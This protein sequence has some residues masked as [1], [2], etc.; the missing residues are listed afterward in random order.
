MKQ[1]VWEKIKHQNYS[2][3]NVFLI[4]SLYYAYKNTFKIAEVPIHFRK[5]ILGKSKTP[6]L[7]ES[8]KALILPL[9]IRF[10]RRKL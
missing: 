7:K 1:N 2:H 5:R 10:F 4:E 8:L 9:K 3:G 6:I